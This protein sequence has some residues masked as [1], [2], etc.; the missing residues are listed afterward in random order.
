MASRL[1][2]MAAA[3]AVVF[4]GMLTLAPAAHADTATAE[5]QFVNLINTLRQSKGLRPL[6]VD[7]RL[8]TVARGWSANMASTGTLAHNPSFSAQAPSDWLKLGE[9]V[10][11]GPDVNAIHTAFV[12]SP[13]HYANLVDADFNAV[14]V[15]VVV[16]GST[17]WVTEDFEKSASAPAV[18]T[19]PVASQPIASHITQGYWL[20]ARDG[21]VF[22][23]GTA[24]FKGSTGGIKLN[25]PIVGMTKARSVGYWFVAADGGIFSYSA[26][27]Y[28]ST[29]NIH[30][31]QPIVGMAATPSGLGYWL[32]A[33]DGG[34]FSFGDA[35]FFGSTGGIKL[36]SPIVGM[37]PTRSGRGYWMVAADGGIFAFGDAAFYGSKG[38]AA[39]SAPIVGMAVTPT[40]RGYWFAAADGSVFSFGDGGFFGAA[41]G[42]PIAGAITGISAASSG[43]GYRL[44]SSSGQVF[45]FGS[46]EYDGALSGAPLNQPVVGIASV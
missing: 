3:L 7:P 31:N 45:P 27:F 19:A 33:R 35:G 44:A 25:Q 2:R 40:G 5:T 13:H 34:V 9:N 16:S 24:G 1:G 22:S 38:G 6:A 15:G 36:N 41:A 43:G 20:V 21:G 46:A 11:Y 39:L 30:L 23:F 14:G 42:R 10:G 26:P 8:T 12:N 32:V 17:M 29:G 37:A 18:N 4:T 28:G